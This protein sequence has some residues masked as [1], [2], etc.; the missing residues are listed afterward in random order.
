MP[1]IGRRRRGGG[2]ICVPLDTTAPTL[3]AAADGTPTS[4]GSTG[5]GVTTDEGNGTLYWAVVTNAGSCTDAQLK[6]GSGGN[7]VAGVAGNQAVSAS[8][9]QVIADITGLTAATTYQIKFLHRDAAGNDS[10]QASVDLTT[11][12]AAS[13][14]RYWRVKNFTGTT[15]YWETS[16]VQLLDGVTVKTGGITPTA[17]AAPTVGALSSLT[18]GTLNFGQ[19]AFTTAVANTLALT[20]DFTSAVTI[21]DIKISRF[22]T[23]GRFPTG[24]ITLEWSDDNAAWTSAGTATLTQPGSNYTLSTAGTFA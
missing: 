9:A 16:E 2:P 14:H 1:V 8:G 3:S 22:D 20:W 19:V 15:T 5:A 24:A 13:S 12:A 6:A 18:D 21:T 4:D 7:I 23:A 10:A 11:A 17:S